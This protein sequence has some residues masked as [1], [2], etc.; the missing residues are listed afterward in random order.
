ML[1]KTKAIRKAM[2]VFFAV[3]MVSSTTGT[4]A[5]ADA[6]S[7]AVDHN[8]TRSNRG[9]VGDDGGLGAAHE[10]VVL[11]TKHDTAK[12]SINN[13]RS[14]GEGRGDNTSITAHIITKKIPTGVGGEDND[15][16]I[17]AHILVKKIPTSSGDDGEDPR[18][19]GG[20]YTT[21]EECEA[22]GGKWVVKK[23]FD[24]GFCFIRLGVSSDTL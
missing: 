3:L 10:D 22:A 24:H 20:I 2:V 16:V 17:L 13:I 23:G 21:K 19:R 12:S 5:A 18:E 4:V 9:I 11:K 8:S 14:I 15:T 6:T 1:G 7:M